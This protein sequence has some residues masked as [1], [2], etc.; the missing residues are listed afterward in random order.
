MATVTV[1]SKFQ[2][3]I[4]TEVRERHGVK[5]GQKLVMFDTG[6][7]VIHLVPL[8]PLTALRGLLKGTEVDLD[9]LREEEDFD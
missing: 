8:L 7:D 5:A 4:P 1:S 3:V 2:I 6:G 9:S